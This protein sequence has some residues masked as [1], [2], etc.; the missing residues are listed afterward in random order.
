MP[1]HA[2]T[3][4]CLLRSPDAVIEPSGNASATATLRRSGVSGPTWS[5]DG[6]VQRILRHPKLP[7][8]TAP[9]AN[10]FHRRDFRENLWY[11]TR[12]CRREVR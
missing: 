10:S 1:G 8:M 7:R 5:G 11:L 9:S 4:R 6:I 2:P 12:Q 3:P